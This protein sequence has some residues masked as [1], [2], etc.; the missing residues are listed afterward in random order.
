MLENQVVLITGCSSGIG[1]ALVQE[2]AATGHCVIATARKRES[3]EDLSGDRVDILELDVTDH[4]AIGETVATA[5]D[6]YGRIDIVVNNAGYALIGPV[7]ELDLDDLRTQFETNVIG[8]VAVIR[9]VVPAM[10]I[11]S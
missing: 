4:G 3:I 8:V 11:S 7:A 10:R 1:R 6:R 5:I 2:F 9:A